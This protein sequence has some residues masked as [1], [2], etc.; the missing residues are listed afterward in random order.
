MPTLQRRNDGCFFV[1]HFYREHHTW[2]IQGEGVRFLERR[3]IREGSRF[4]TDLFMELWMRGLVYHGNSTANRPIALCRDT[5][6]MAAVRTHVRK[7]HQLIY[8]T[9]VDQAWAMVWEN[10]PS[11]LALEQFRVE[12]GGNP[13]G[14]RS[15]SIRDIVL[16]DLPADFQPDFAGA[17]RFAGVTVQISLAAS[18]AEFRARD[19]TQ[20]WLEFRDEWRVAW[21][22]FR[23]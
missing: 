10:E 18:E 16:Y 20:Y 11:T 6:A 3:G 12:V 1:S 23:S 4:P 17:K 22:P 7:F 5:V 2:Q 13:Y 9:K 15:W 8:S 19:V 21:N 14:L